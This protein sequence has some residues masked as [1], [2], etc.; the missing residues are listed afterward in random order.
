MCE[1]AEIVPGMCREKRQTAR[2]RRERHA[3][4]QQSRSREVPV[5]R[6]C[7]SSYPLIFEIPRE[8]D[9]TQEK[10]DAG[11]SWWSAKKRPFL[12]ARDNINAVTL[13]LVV[14]DEMTRSVFGIV[15]RLGG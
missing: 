3:F 15:R 6:C 7:S 13:I 11:E 10:G 12:D 2:N 14:L 1:F 8:E 5:D 9:G 4:V